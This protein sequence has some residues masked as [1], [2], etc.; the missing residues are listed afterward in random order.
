MS[1]VRQK[2]DKKD[3]EGTCYD[4]LFFSLGL[5]PDLVRLTEL[6]ALLF[7]F[8]FWLSRESCRS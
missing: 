5:Y 2:A 7:F 8:F 3:D 1:I 4:R 6:P